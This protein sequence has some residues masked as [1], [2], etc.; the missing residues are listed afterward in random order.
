MFLSEGFGR[1]V[2]L[3]AGAEPEEGV[4]EI[5]SIFKAS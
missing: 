5:M 2:G 1:L 4:T 3:G